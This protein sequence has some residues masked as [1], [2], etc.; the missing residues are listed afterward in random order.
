MILATVQ[1]RAADQEGK[2]SILASHS[3]FMQRKEREEGFATDTTR[4]L[5]SC[6]ADRLIGLGKLSS[7]VVDR[8]MLWWLR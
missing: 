5:V 3:Q 7:V 4:K 8:G 1:E 2:P 6:P